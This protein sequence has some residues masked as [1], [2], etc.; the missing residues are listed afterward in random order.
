MQLHGFT[1]NIYLEIGFYSV[2]S[3]GLTN[4]LFN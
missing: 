1:K 2:I 4:S 3:V